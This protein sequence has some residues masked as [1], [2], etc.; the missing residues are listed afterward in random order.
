MTLPQLGPRGEGWVIAQ[1]AVGGAVAALGA[2][3]LR[4]SRAPLPWIRI[5]IGAALMTVGLWA[6][7]RGSIDLGASLT[8]MPRPHPD[9]AL[10]DTGIYAT[11]RHPIYAGI[12]ALC[13]GWAILTGSGAALAASV[14]EGLVFWGKS[15]VEEEWLRARYPEY[16]AYAARTH[17]FIPGL[18]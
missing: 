7:A 6:A 2:A 1:F 13:F 8:P 9:S 18:V 16:T 12:G 11:I 17:R 14:A 4:T 3:S 5:P 10:V 15:T